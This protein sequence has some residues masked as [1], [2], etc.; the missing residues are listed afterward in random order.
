MH[1][2][3]IDPKNMDDVKF[4]YEMLKERPPEINISHNEM[5]TIDDHVKFVQ[6]NP[7][8]KWYIIEDDHIKMGHCNIGRNIM[9]DN[10]IGYWLRPKYQRKGIGTMAV[11][12]MMYLNPRKRYLANIAP[13]NTKSQQFIESLGFKKCQCTYELNTS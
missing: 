2:R 10:E 7:Y 1:L 8:K 5:P 4:L 6:S 9:L 11:K 13:K 12:D 3:E